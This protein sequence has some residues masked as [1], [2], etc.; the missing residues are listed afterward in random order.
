MNTLD[1]N[2]IAE[3]LLAAKA[4]ATL[5]VPPTDRGEFSVDAGYAVVGQLHAT[6][7]QR[8][9]RPV[10]R[11]IGFTN[12]QIWEEYG[13]DS[14]LWAYVYERTVRQGAAQG[15]LALSGLIQPR[16]EPEIVFG[17]RAPLAPGTTDPEALLD[18]VGWYAPGFEVVEC[19]YAEWR[20]RIADYVADFGLHGALFVGPPISVDHSRSARLIDQ[21]ERFTVELLCDGQVVASGGGA[22]VLGSPLLALGFLSE[23]LARQG[24]APL[25]AGEIITTGT[26]TPALPLLDGQTWSRTADGLDLAPLTLQIVS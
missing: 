12:R 7:L 18:A 26:L 13:V 10:G 22:N 25:A 8:G 15:V 5:I 19:H 23:T 16:I 20:C 3:E 17:L 2:L 24:A 1:L 14:P 21:L 11:K 9:D 6:L 4:L